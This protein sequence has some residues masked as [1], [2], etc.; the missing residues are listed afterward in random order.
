[1]KI[2]QVITSL[3]TGGAEMLVTNMIPMLI[4]LG[5]QVNLCVFNN[6]ETPLLKKLRENCPGITIYGLGNS[7]YNISYIPR[8]VKIIKN[9]DIIHSHN[10][11]PQL[12]VA[13]ANLFQHKTLVTTEHSTN[14]RRRTLRFFYYIDKWMYYQ[15]NSVVC[16]SEIA[17]KR[18][19]D[20][21]KIRNN[22]VQQIC[23][24]NNGI[25]VDSFHKALPIDRKSINSTDNKFVVIMVAGFREAKDQDTLIRAIVRL[26]KDKFEL[27]LVGDGVR[28][29]E[30]E[31]QIKEVHAEKQVKL[32]GLRFDVPSILKS[33][34]VI[35]MSSHWEGLSL[36]NIEGM[37]V[38]KPFIASNVNGLREITQNYGIL[39]PH[40]DDK[41]LAEIILKL[42]NDKEYYNKV[43]SQ[44]YKRAQDFDLQKTTN[45]YSLLYNNLI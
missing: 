23:V 1:M 45:S 26:P 13:I 21:L 19:K 30:I 5:H 34:D 32:L 41:S 12:F 33:A 29:K 42:S 18:L 39:F 14:N 44:C 4:D 11:S 22:R 17:E 2:L 16:I 35:V 6:K 3:E 8:L 40:E 27:W 10:Y 38:G 15:Y 43:A 36:S 31:R 24:I 25:N 7:F 37:S 9:Y 20:Y 28:R